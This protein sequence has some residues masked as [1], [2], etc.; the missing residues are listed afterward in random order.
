MACARIEFA[1]IVVVMG[2]AG[3]GKTTV[4]S[5]LAARLRWRFIDADD[6]HPPANVAKMASGRPLSDDDREPW[7]KA[8]EGTLAGLAADGQ[9]AVL[10]C[11]AL[12]AAFR[13]RLHLG[14]GDIRF[15]YLRA[16]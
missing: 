13:E 14:G 5:M 2:V 4:G 10:A 7:L 11:S 16:G 6:L 1:M 15:V 9:S 12:R 3:A 8:I